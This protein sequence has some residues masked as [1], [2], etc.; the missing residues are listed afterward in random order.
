MFRRRD[1]TAQQLSPLEQKEVY[2]MIQKGGE[3]PL[4]GLRKPAPERPKGT[5]YF[6][7]WS[8]INLTKHVSVLNLKGVGLLFY[9]KR[10]V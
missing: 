7:F 9:K 3:V 8:F 6:N 4:H 5:F 1:E 10:F 2:K